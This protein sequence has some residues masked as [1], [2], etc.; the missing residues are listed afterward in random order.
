VLYDR[1]HTTG[2]AATFTGLA[3]VIAVD[4]E[5]PPLLVLGSRG[6]LLLLLIVVFFG[7]GDGFATASSSSS[8]SEII[9]FLRGRP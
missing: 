8:S 9:T 3:G 7:G 5:V 6:L 2:R 1:E 4:S